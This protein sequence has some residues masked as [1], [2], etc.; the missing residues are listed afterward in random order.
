MRSFRTSRWSHS[1]YT[2][3]VRHPRGAGQQLRRRYRLE[4][5]LFRTHPVEHVP[6]QRAVFARETPAE[7]VLGE[8][9]LEPPAPKQQPICTDGRHAAYGPLPACSE[10]LDRARVRPSELLIAVAR[11]CARGERCEQQ[12]RSL[13][14]LVHGALERGLVGRRGLGVTAD[15]AHVLQ[16]GVTDLS[17]GRG[18]I[19]VEEHPDV[20]AHAAHLVRAS[21]CHYREATPR[22]RP[23]KAR[24]ARRRAAARATRAASRGS[25]PH[26]W[27]A[28]SRG[29]RARRRA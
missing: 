6:T 25:R 16:R 9:R 20:P 12:R 15:L 3:A 2:N 4:G 24:A 18:R 27:R 8:V 11:W 10:P 13:G 5:G 14:D 28:R 17:A 22:A 7:A 26:V 29:G 23:P 21:A 1:Q 19:E